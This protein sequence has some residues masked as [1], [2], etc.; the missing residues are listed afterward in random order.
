MAS[1]CGFPKCTLDAGHGGDFHVGPPV[2]P[3]NPSRRYLY[4]KAE[5]RDRVRIATQSDGPYVGVLTTPGEV[6][7]DA[8]Y[9]KRAGLDE[10]V[11]EIREAEGG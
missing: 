2:E 6:D 4:P 3:D 7:E 10:L 9:R 8:I 5:A 1:T 11:R